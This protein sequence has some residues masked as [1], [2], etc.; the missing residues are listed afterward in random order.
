MAIEER[1]G[2]QWIAVVCSACLD[3]LV[4]HNVWW[5]CRRLPW[6]HGWVEVALCAGETMSWGRSAEAM[7][8]VRGRSFGVEY[9]CS[10]SCRQSLR[11]IWSASWCGWCGETRAWVRGS[12]MADVVR[13]PRVVEARI[14]FFQLVRWC[15]LMQQHCGEG[16]CTAVSLLVWWCLPPSILFRRYF[17]SVAFDIFYIM[18]FVGWVLWFVFRLCCR[19]LSFVLRPSWCPNPTGKCWVVTRVD[20]PIQPVSIVLFSF[21][22]F[23]AYNLPG[24]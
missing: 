15:T 9:L 22:S 4:W 7:L 1:L 11:R 23:P 12:P 2:L 19:L 20:V 13:P 6:Y 16:S 10:P 3:L 21:F 18:W 17:T 14:R 8:V 5:R 24:L